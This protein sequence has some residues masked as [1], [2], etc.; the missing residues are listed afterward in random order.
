MNLQ[1]MRYAIIG[2]VALLAALLFPTA[3]F[4]QRHVVKCENIRSLTV[5]ADGDWQR[6]PITSL[7]DGYIDIDFDEMS[8]TYHR[9]SYSLIHCEGDW[10]ESADLFPSDYVN[11]YASGNLIDDMQQSLLTNNLYTHYHLQLPNRECAFKLGGNYK[12]IVL[13]ED[14]EGDTV[15]T[16]CFMVLDEKM[17]VGLEWTAVTDATVNDRHQ[18]IAMSVSYNGMQVTNPDKQLRTVLVQNGR[19]DDARVNARPQYNSGSKL[20][21]SHCK[22]YIF[23]ALNEYRKF[24]ILSTDVASMG[25]ERLSWDGKQLYA[26]PFMQTLRPNYLTDVDADGHFMIRNSDNQNAD[27][28]SEYIYVNF[29]LKT[30][31]PLANDVYVSGGFTNDWFKPEFKMEYDPSAGVYEKAV[32]LKMGYYNYQFLSR[33]ADGKMRLLPGDGN[34]YQTENTYQA[35]VY[36]R[37]VGG[38][39]DNLVGYSQIRTE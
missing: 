25:I 4:G 7:T 13:D 24:E 33:G 26:Y 29:Q 12:L 23:D 11:G 2:Q 37:P 3:T 20:S 35:F 38:R 9:Y 14:N 30:G 19:W 16:A 21:W 18:Q 8:H 31:G 39:T 34:F 10:S 32:L 1:H 6:L 28:E 36:Y 22:D 27:N 5:V 15:L 17:N